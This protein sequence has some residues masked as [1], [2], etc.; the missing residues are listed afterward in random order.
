MTIDL[1]APRTKECCDLCR[2]EAE[3]FLLLATTDA[4]CLACFVM[5]H[6]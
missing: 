3:L 4:L 2:Q 6:G 5:L 1:D